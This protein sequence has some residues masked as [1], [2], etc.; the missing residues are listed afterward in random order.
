MSKPKRFTVGGV[1]FTAIRF[2][3]PRPHWRCRIDETAEVLQAGAGGI[4]TESVPKMQASLTELLE[5]VSKG[6]AKEFRRR[7]DLEGMPPLR[8][9]ALQQLQADAKDL[10]AAAARKNVTLDAW[11]LREESHMAQE[12]FELGCWLHHLRSRI[13]RSDGLAARIECVRRLFDEGITEP[14]YMFFTVFDFGEREFDTCFEMDDS[15]LVKARLLDIAEINP[16]SNVARCVKEMGWTRE[17][18]KANAERQKGAVALN[19]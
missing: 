3:R 5:R 10:V 6:D 13:G 8:A 4:S 1:R 16:D 9:S 11:E 14:G 15:H 17:Q 12:H 19:T 18:S 2:E 7:F